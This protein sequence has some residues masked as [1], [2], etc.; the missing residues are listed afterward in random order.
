MVVLWD[1]PSVNFTL[2]M[3]NHHFKMET[4]TISMAILNSYVRLEEGNIPASYEADKDGGVSCIM[5]WHGI[6]N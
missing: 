1:L 2:L 4:H 3:G 5:R 6:S